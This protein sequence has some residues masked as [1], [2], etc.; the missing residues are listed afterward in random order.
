MKLPPYLPNDPV[1]VQDW[2]QYLDTV[3]YTDWEVGQILNRLDTSGDLENTYVFF[4]TDHGISH[5]RNKQF[6]YEGGVHV[7]FIVR[8]PNLTPAVRDDPIEHIDMGATSLALAGIEIP[9]VMQSRNVLGQ[10]YVPRE[11]A[12]SARDRCDETVDRMRCVRSERF[13]YIRNFLPNRPW[14]QP[15]RYK[16][17]KPI[18]R[19]MRRLH[20]EGKLNEAQARIMSGR[21]PEEELYDLQS[22]PFELNNLAGNPDHADVQQRMRTALADWIRHTGDRGQAWEGAMYDSDMQAYLKGDTT[23]PKGKEL[24]NNIALMKKWQSEGK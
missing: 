22:D 9:T 4:I 10:D 1:I 8:G 20:A 23:S 11:F 21:R 14:L 6:M 13:K 2:A 3:R 5:V 17:N 16:D 19:A 24:V 15:N 18:I 12:F 7:P